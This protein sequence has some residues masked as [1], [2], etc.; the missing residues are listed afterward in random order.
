M[1]ILAVH[2]LETSPE[3]CIGLAPPKVQGH[4]T[5][6]LPDIGESRRHNMTTLW[7]HKVVVRSRNDFT[8]TALILCTIQS[9]S[10]HSAI[11][12]QPGKHSRRYQ[13]ECRRHKHR[14]LYLGVV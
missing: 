13:I 3:V 11:G 8:L 9:S 12:R 10:L 5:R 7:P 4:N 6:T 14:E 1:P 2:L